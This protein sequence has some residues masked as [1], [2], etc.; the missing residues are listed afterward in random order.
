M[1]ERRTCTGIYRGILRYRAVVGFLRCPLTLSNYVSILSF[2]EQ[3]K[4]PS[5]G[6]R[7]A[8]ANDT[9]KVERSRKLSGLNKG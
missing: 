2:E 5:I 1:L 9:A 6:K 7:R 4:G 3:A 8:V